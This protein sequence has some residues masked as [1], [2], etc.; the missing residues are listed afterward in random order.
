MSYYTLYIKCKIF[1]HLTVL[2]GVVVQWVYS[3]L[4]AGAEPVSQ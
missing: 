3:I 2:T 1:V 4:Q